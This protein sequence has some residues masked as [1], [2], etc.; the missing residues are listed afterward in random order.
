MHPRSQIKTSI[1]ESQ[2][3]PLSPTQEGG[4][5]ARDTRPLRPAVQMSVLRDR[6][7][8]TENATLSA[9]SFTSGWQSHTSCVPPN[10][11]PPLYRVRDRARR[12]GTLVLPRS[13][14]KVRRRRRLVLRGARQR[15]RLGE[16]ER[17]RREQVPRVGDPVRREAG[18]VV[19]PGGG[20]RRGSDSSKSRFALSA[21]GATT[22]G[23][24]VRLRMQPAGTFGCCHLHS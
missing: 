21:L 9:P 19:L 3:D 4:R 15:A 5:G 7:P 22:R 13:S 6:L 2:S 11:D 1:Q 10:G 23:I 18:A 20:S 8:P 16:N 12:R 24:G 17:Q 14:A